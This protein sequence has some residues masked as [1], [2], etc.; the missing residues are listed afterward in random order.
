MLKCQAKAPRLVTNDDQLELSQPEQALCWDLGFQVYNAYE[1]HSLKKKVDKLKNIVSTIALEQVVLHNDLT[2][3]ARVTNRAFA[4]L[5]S[6]VK[7]LEMLLHGTV[8]ILFHA[9]QQLQQLAVRV[10][11]MEQ[12]EYVHHVINAT[13]T[14]YLFKYMWLQDVMVQQVSIL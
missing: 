1:L 13:I 9:T 6:S 5:T 3:L 11:A 14:P 4:K 10:K 7:H 2:V 8:D 12:H